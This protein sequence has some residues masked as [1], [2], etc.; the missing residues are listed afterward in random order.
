MLILVALVESF[1]ER[2]ALDALTLDDWQHRLAKTHAAAA[3]DRDILCL[4]DSLMKLAVLPRIVEA[5]SGLRTSNL[6]VCSSQAPAHLAILRRALSAGARPKAVLIDSCPMLLARGPE[7]GVE[8]WP[9]LLEGLEC[10]EL[11][12]R[13]K[14]PSLAAR[15]ILARWLPTL[16][17]RA[18]VRTWIVAAIDG[19]SSPWR[20]E[21]P[22]AFRNWRLN[23]G[24]QPMPSRPQPMVAVDPVIYQ[25]YCFPAG[26]RANRVNTEYLRRFLSLAEAHDV[27]VYWLIPPI[28]P[29]VEAAALHSGFPQ[30]FDQFLRTLQTQHPNLVVLDARG[31]GY[32]PDVFMDPEHLGREGAQALSEDLGDLFR[33]LRRSDLPVDRWVHLPSFRPR[34]SD[35][36]VEDLNASRAFVFGATRQ[37]VR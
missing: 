30:R 13:L 34:P 15:M 12:F 22:A 1:V 33:R 6:A 16:R 24:A 8:H 36:S 7:L 5:R 21:T 29:S 9:H 23:G 35:S 31:A 2:H 3:Q 11:G 26:W 37:T 10:L 14:Q 4:G 18:V 19:A 17:S 25:R 32:H 27:T 20:T 28:L